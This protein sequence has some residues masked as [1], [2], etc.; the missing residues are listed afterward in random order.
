MEAQPP[1]I[2]QHK[3]EAKGLNNK[4]RPR[5]STQKE[6]L[7]PRLQSILC[8]QEAVAVASLL[9][10]PTSSRTLR[11]AH[12]TWAAGLHMAISL[13]VEEWAQARYLLGDTSCGVQ[14]QPFICIF[15]GIGFTLGQVTLAVE[16]VDPILT[17]NSWRMSF[18]DR[19]PQLKV[20]QRVK[21]LLAGLL[22]FLKTEDS[23]TD[24]L[25]FRK[26]F[27]I[28]LKLSCLESSLQRSG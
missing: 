1:K 2:E 14:W 15:E 3:T 5:V 27:V 11:P 25:D 17:Y 21:I 13:S 26:V 22:S 10:L 28:Q 9:T 23:G 19:P 16:V 4:K 8:G 18:V 7:K 24:F 6:S 20:R 12:D